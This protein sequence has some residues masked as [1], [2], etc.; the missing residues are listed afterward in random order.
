L[1][2]ALR[3]VPRPAL[4]DRRTNV[5]AL[6]DRVAWGE[7]SMDRA[8]DLG[9]DGE[10]L[11]RRLRPVAMPSQLVHA[12]PSEGNLLFADGLPPALI[13]ISPYWRPA[14]YGVAMFVADAIAWSGAPVELLERVRA[15]PEMAQLLARAVLFRLIVAKLWRGGDD[16]VAARSV[17]YA[18]VIEAVELWTR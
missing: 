13:D 5:F 10:R 17:A 12:D 7:M 8:G 4:L 15:T 16:G 18:P 11:L 14:E 1:H 9:P 6:A 3:A 2:R